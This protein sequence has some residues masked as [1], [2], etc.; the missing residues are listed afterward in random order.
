[1][2]GHLDFTAGAA[3]VTSLVAAA[4][5]PAVLAVLRGS[6][7]CVIATRCSFSRAARSSLRLG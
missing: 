7:A 1:M 2:L 3:V 6:R 4:V 5:F